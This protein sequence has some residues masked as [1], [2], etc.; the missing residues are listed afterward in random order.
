ML[1]LGGKLLQTFTRSEKIF[2][3]VR[4]AVVYRQ[5]EGLPQVTVWSP[6]AAISWK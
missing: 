2:P 1:V 4:A 6:S 3:R 5:L